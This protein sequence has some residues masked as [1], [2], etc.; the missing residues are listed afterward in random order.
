M[1]NYCAVQLEGS[2]E[3]KLSVNLEP[4]VR[5]SVNARTLGFRTEEQRIWEAEE[6]QAADRQYSNGWLP[7]QGVRLPS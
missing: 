4:G 1:E 2:T 3:E 6:Q 5:Y 7:Q